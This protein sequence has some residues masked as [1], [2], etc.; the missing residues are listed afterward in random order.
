M[1]EWRI[2]W[3][4]VCLGVEIRKEIHLAFHV[5]HISEILLASAAAARVCC[6]DR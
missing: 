3:E 5:V 4:D 1:T 6:W 2:R